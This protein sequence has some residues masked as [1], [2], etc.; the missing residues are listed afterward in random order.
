MSEAGG[1]EQGG[2]SEEEVDREA[3]VGG[4]LYSAKQCGV[5]E[6]VGVG[7]VCGWGTDADELAECASLLGVLGDCG[8]LVNDVVGQEVD[9]ADYNEDGW[10]RGCEVEEVCDFERIGV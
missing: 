6:R 2:W 3:G 9:P 7:L 10:S 8:Q 1:T 4:G 5:G